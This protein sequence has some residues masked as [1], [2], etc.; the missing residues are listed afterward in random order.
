MKFSEFTSSSRKSLENWEKTTLDT[1]CSFDNLKIYGSFMIQLFLLLWQRHP[2]L[3]CEGKPQ[4]SLE[5]SGKG[6]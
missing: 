5:I 1:K 3:F 4:R 6:N 2:D